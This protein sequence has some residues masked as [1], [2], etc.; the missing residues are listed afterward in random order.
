MELILKAW[1]Y[2]PFDVMGKATRYY[3]DQCARHDWEPGPDPI[4]FPSRLDIGQSGVFQLVFGARLTMDGFGL[5]RY[6]FHAMLPRTCTTRIALCRRSG[7]SSL[8]AAKKARR[9][10][11][12]DQAWPSLPPS[13]ESPGAI[14]ESP[15]CTTDAVAREHVAARDRTTARARRHVLRVEQPLVDAERSMKPHA[16]AEARL[17]R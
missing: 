4:I 7:V 9:R 17:L 12:E 1:T 6:S 16:V 14:C 5:W 13:A 11:R 15:S 8:N 2:G 3:R 10:H